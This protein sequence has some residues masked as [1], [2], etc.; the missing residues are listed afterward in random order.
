[1]RMIAQNDLTPALSLKKARVDNV[2]ARF[3]APGV[4]CC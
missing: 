3:I 4:L 1:M 2:G